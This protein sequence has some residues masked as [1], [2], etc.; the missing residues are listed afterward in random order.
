MAK[1]T[2]DDI[3]VH[4]VEKLYSGFFKLNKYHVSHPLFEGG[5]SNVITREVFERGHAAAV[6][7]FDPSLD[8][9]VLI[10]QFRFPAF[11]TMQS[12]WLVEVVAGILESGEKAD[13]L[14][15][16]EA[17]EEAGMAISNL[18]KIC[19]FLPSPGACTESIELF[20]GQVD[21][22]KAFGVHGLEYEA[23]DIKVLRVSVDEA[24]KWLENGRINNSTAIIAVQWLLLNKQKLLTQWGCNESN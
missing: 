17:Q 3:T 16:R 15:H 6:L 20:I 14:C 13:E 12:P 4:K 5:K 22:T 19:A 8:E 24:A 2:R 9:L 23:E 18:T 7:M 11:D 21:A 1:F 10:E